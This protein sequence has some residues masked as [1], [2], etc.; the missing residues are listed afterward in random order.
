M[1]SHPK[2]SSLEKLI[3]HHQS[4]RSSHTLNSTKANRKDSK[5][6]EQPNSSDHALP[7]KP[8]GEIKHKSEEEASVAKEES[9]KSS[10]STSSEEAPD[11]YRKK[12]Y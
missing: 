9:P 8:P 3:D 12:T 6:N 2:Q 11:L 4:E 1:D 7:P 10:S 5:E